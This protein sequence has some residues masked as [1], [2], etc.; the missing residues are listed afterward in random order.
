MMHQPYREI[1]TGTSEAGKFL[2][3]TLGCAL[4]L[5][6]M[7]VWQRPSGK[8]FLFCSRGSELFLKRKHFPTHYFREIKR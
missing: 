3:F 7:Q 6:T 5:T 1:A 4:R 8:Y 2:D